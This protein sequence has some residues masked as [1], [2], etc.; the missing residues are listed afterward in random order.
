MNEA[1]GRFGAYWHG[2]IWALALVGLYLT[3]RYS[4]PHL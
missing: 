1:S 3:S 2:F 4:L